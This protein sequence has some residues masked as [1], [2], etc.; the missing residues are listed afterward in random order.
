MEKSFEKIGNILFWDLT[1]FLKNRLF[2]EKSFKIS[3]KPELQSAK[4]H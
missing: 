4:I 1:S 3:R 2:L